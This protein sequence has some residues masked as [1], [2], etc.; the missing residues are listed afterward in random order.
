MWSLLNP[1]LQCLP[2]QPNGEASPWAERSSAGECGQVT[3]TLNRKQ[4][5]GRLNKVL[6]LS[7]E[8]RRWTV[9]HHVCILPSFFFFFHCCTWNAGRDEDSQ[10]KH[11]SCPVWGVEDPRAHRVSEICFSPGHWGGL[12]WWRGKVQ[13]VRLD[14]ILQLNFTVVEIANCWHWGVHI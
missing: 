14:Q 1:C 11:P 10:R 6:H 8:W 4:S 3:C 9:A 13:S 5:S 7:K 12:Q 2:S